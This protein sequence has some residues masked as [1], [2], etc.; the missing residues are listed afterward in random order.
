MS[1]TK[2][3]Y[4]MIDGAVFNVRDYGAVGDGVN[5]DTAAIQ[6]AINATA[7]LG[8]VFFPKGT[9]KITDTIDIIY[10]DVWQAV[11]LM[12]V[13]NASKIDWRGGNGKP[14]IHTRGPGTNGAGFYAKPFIEKL[15]LYGNAFTGDLY[16]NVTGVQVGDTPQNALSGVCNFTIR[17]CLIRHTTIGIALFY[18]SDEFTIDCN[19]IEKFTG[20]GIYNQEGGSGGWIT[21]NHISDGGATSV[22][23]YS[24]LSSST[25]EQNIIQGSQIGVGILIAG[26]AALRGKATSI[27]NNY[28]ESQASADYAIALYGTDTAVIE[29]NTM[30][31][32]PG[33]TLIFLADDADG[34]SC[35]N[36]QLGVNRHTQSAGFIVALASASANSVNCR[37]TGYQQTDG[38]VTNI[39]GPFQ[40]TQNLNDYQSGSFTAKLY[41][42]TTQQT[43]IFNAASYTKIGRV[44]YINGTIA[45]TTAVSGTGDAT[46]QGLPFTTS[47]FAA[48]GGVISLSIANV[49]NTGSA[50]A[51][52]IVNS[53][54]LQLWSTATTGVRTALTN[55]DFA[56]TSEV[57]FSGFYLV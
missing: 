43:T 13:G 17:D 6:A 4:S 2:V 18:E 47:S 40:Q 28:L 50:S 52:T 51:T 12:G 15:Q 38:A 44:V 26:L 19:Y 41:F 57:N 55:A 1:L 46:L 5:D 24:S 22:G 11:N 10:I 20:Y 35:R 29:N 14:M 48:F 56:S 23:I 32:F 30:N 37:I 34:V 54:K 53:D 3:S 21:K 42:G 36:V 25:I 9:Y 49:T 33:A 27:R 45:M 39:V 7:N 16:T 8:T 31:G